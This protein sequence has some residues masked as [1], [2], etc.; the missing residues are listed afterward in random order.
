MNNLCTLEQALALGVGKCDPKAG[1]VEAF[2]LSR[3]KKVLPAGANA[4]SVI[5]GWLNDGSAIMLAG[6]KQRDP[7]NESPVTGSL[8]Y[9]YEEQLRGA[10]LQD[11]FVFPQGLCSQV[12]HAN[13]VGFKGYAL[14]ITHNGQLHG[15]KGSVSGSVEMF[16]L[17]VTTMDTTGVFADLANI[18]TDTLTLKYGELQNFVNRRS[19]TTPNVV[20][21]DFVN[22]IALELQGKSSALQILDACMGEPINTEVANLE[23]M[24]SRVN[25]VDR[26]ATITAGTN[27]NYVVA[28]TP[29]LTAGQTATLQLK[30]KDGENTAGISNLHSYVAGS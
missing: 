9:G 1:A 6:M 2:I 26:P 27:G 11:N 23:V 25:G 4:Q 13:L 20:I 22:P 12:G 7:N 3:T 24:T 18:Q 16:P 5:Q 15:F 17:S 29:A 21:S 30:W 19:V 8:A 28:W 10:I 14:A